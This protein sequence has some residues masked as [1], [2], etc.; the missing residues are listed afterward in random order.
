ME[1]GRDVDVLCTLFYDKEVRNEYY[2]G[3]VY[4]MH[5]T[6]ELIHV[7]AWDM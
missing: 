3:H 4:H 5:G 2:I 7:H 6:C 1:G